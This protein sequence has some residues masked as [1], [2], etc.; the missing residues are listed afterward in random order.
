MNYYQLWINKETWFT[1]YH[2]LA[3]ERGAS[4]LMKGLKP[5]NGML[6]GCLHIIYRF[7][8]RMM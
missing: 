8:K 5:S 4:H 3:W 1:F 6:A 7:I 2:K